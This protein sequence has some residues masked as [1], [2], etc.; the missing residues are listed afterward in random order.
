M[1]LKRQLEG[2]SD[3]LWVEIT[4]SLPQSWSQKQMDHDKL[5]EKENW[6][7]TLSDPKY[8]QSHPVPAGWECWRA[9]DRDGKLNKLVYFLKPDTQD[10][11][12]MLWTSGLD[13][14][15]PHPPTVALPQMWTCFAKG[16]K[17][18]YEKLE[19]IGERMGWRLVSRVY[20]TLQEQSS[21]S[22]T[23]PILG[24]VQFSNH[25]A[26]YSAAEE[27]AARVKRYSGIEWFEM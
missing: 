21:E 24:P 18:K 8:I 16:G 23:M 15:N 25:R 1:H 9:A 20:D 17:L 13:D 11:T 7:Q 5:E 22:I 6:C 26:F 3:T 10:C 2:A 27:L 12:A 14:E 19:R 4:F